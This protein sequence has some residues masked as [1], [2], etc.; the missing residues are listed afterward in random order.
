MLSVVERFLNYMQI[1]NIF[2]FLCY[3]EQLS[4]AASRRNGW[5]WISFIKQ[6]LLVVKQQS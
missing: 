1:P 2:T 5:I 4:V 6:P 3:F